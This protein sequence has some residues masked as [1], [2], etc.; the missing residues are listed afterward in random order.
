MK[1]FADDAVISVTDGLPSGG[2][3]V[4]EKHQKQV[5]R[6]F[7]K[8]P[9]RASVVLEIQLVTTAASP[10]ARP[11]KLCRQRSN[12]DPP[13][14]S[15]RA[16]S[17]RTGSSR[18]KNNIGH[19]SYWRTDCQVPSWLSGNYW[20][21]FDLV[22]LVHNTVWP[23][24]RDHWISG[25]RT[26]K[27]PWFRDETPTNLSVFGWILH[28]NPSE[29]DWF[30]LSLKTTTIRISY[31]SKTWWKKIKSYVWKQTF[32]LRCFCHLVDFL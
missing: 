6:S 26:Q 20:W 10:T 1:L 18:L 25:T 14:R 31:D 4:P 3:R 7:V 32:A 28:F 30:H 22:F 2:W 24:S 17:G 9:A 13:Q 21:M 8:H 23:L 29:T 27:I 19:P 12:K 16:R 15:E 11:S 5:A